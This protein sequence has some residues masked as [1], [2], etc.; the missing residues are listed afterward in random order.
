MRRLIII[1]ALTMISCIGCNAENTLRK[2]IAQMLI[3]GF[4]GTSAEELEAMD[5]GARYNICKLGIGGVVLFDKNVRDDSK[6]K[7]IVSPEQVKSL[8]S[9]LQSLSPEPLLIS[10]DYEGGNVSRL[11]ASYGFPS[12]VSA[13]YLGS[14]MADSI[15]Y[16][17]H[18]TASIIKEYGFNLNFAPCV[19]VNVNPQCPII[20]QK[21]RSFSADTLV[22]SQCAKLWIEAAREKNVL[23]VIKHFPGHG[24]ATEDSHLGLTDVTNTWQE[25]ELA[26][27]RELIDA[28]MADIV[29]VAHVSN[30][31]IDPDYPASLSYR[32]ITGILRNELGF[33]GLVISDDMDMGAITDEYSY[34]KAIELAINAGSDML[35]LGRNSTN[36][37]ILSAEQTI[38]TIVKL[39]KN[40]SISKARINEAYSRIKKLKAKL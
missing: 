13:Q 35:I 23:S 17:A 39:V 16:H 11:E 25:Y 37:N 32:T 31:N 14:Q 30:R 24:S 2:K 22:V 34:E 7:N 12:S 4:D 33:K 21:E 27:F 28:G 3:V 6:A 9:Y 5:D 19:D 1:L 8:T 20:G 18:K 15:S 26:P 10:I 40:G 38:D 36:T 29:M